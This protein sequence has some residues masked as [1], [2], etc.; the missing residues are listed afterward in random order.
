MEPESAY[1]DLIKKLE[2]KRGRCA[3]LNVNGLFHKLEEIK[4]F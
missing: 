3:H 2:P 4:F 1:P